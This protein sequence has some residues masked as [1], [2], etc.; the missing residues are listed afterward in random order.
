MHV[1]DQIGGH[2]VDGAHEAIRVFGGE[3][4]PR[5][6]GAQER[7]ADEAVARQY[8]K[9][10]GAVGLAAI[11]ERPGA[12][13]GRLTGVRRAVRQQPTRLAG[14][15]VKAVTLLGQGRGR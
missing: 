2:R 7:N 3:D 9:R 1:V 13:Q 12:V 15:R 5:H 8:G 14:Q 10:R 6:Q 11:E 4:A